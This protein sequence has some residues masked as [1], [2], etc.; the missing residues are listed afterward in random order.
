MLRVKSRRCLI[1]NCSTQ[2]LKL[3][4]GAQVA[5]CAPRSPRLECLSSSG[6]WCKSIPVLNQVQAR[7]HASCIQPP[8]I[9]TCAE[10]CC[11]RQVTN[12]P[13]DPL[14]EGLVMSL[15]VRLGKRGNLLEPGPGAYSQARTR[16]QPPACQRFSFDLCICD[17]VL[18]R[19]CLPSFDSRLGIYDAVCVGRNGSRQ[20]SLL[21]ERRRPGTSLR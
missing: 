10:L 18:M 12:P 1:F 9:C 17:F 14:R 8:A 20:C 7:T 2:L 4:A 19:T 6:G 21:H 16:A 11:E 15:A 13:I 5:F 3:A